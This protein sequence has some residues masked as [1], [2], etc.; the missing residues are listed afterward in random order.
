MYDALGRMTNQLDWLGNQMSFVYDNANRLISRAYPNGLVQTNS[1]DNAGRING[2][3]YETGGSTPLIALSYAYDR[4]GN[5]TNSTEAG[6][7]NW[8]LPALTDEKA[9]F[10]P[11]GRLQTRQIQNNSVSSNQ[12]STMTYAYDPSGNMTNAASPQESYAFTYDEDNRVMT[13]NWVAGTTNTTIVNQYDSF[14]RRISRTLDNAT[15]AYVLDLSGNME[16]IL[17]DLNQDLTMTYY[18]HAPDLCYK[19]DYPSGTLT[20]FHADAQA[21]I[22]ATTDTNQNLLSEYA[23]TPYG[24]CLGSTNLQSQISN[25]YTFVGSQG[26]MEELPNLYFMRARY[27]SGESGTFVSADSVKHIGMG[28]KPLAY[29]Y[30]GGNP[31][32]RIDPTGNS[33]FDP[34]V[35]DYAGASSEAQA[36]Y[37]SGYSEGLTIAIDR[38][39]DAASHAIMIPVD[40]FTV[41]VKG[42]VSDASGLLG[43]FA[44][45]VGLARTGAALN[46]VSTGIGLY[47]SAEDLTELVNN[48]SEVQSGLSTLIDK[49]ASD[50]NVLLGVLQEDTP[51]AS[52]ITGVL[53]TGLQIGFDNV[54]DSIGNIHGGMSGRVPTLAASHATLTTALTSEQPAKA[55]NQSGSTSSSV[56][57][58]GQALN[59]LVDSFAGPNLTAAQ[60]QAIA[61]VIKAFSTPA[62]SGGHH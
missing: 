3:S 45:S 21:N 27:Y 8:P 50:P 54:M 38:Y 42:G 52:T 20:C 60:S 30:C 19:I 51:A 49:I 24:R 17:C 32:C 31:L 62:S 25:S 28:E 12:D 61:G 5:K 26:V 40:M 2:L 33:F 22:I 37:F 47:S 23:Y 15:T 16:R 56:S 9:A 6:T 36:A 13:V 18:I 57:A 29:L 59:N 41:N 43:D 53:S 34:P 7:Y 35:S 44:E 14:G 4:N 46:A 11:S 48:F 55:S 10:S 58:Q 39:K 1:F